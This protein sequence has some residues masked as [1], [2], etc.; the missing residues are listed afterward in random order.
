MLGGRLQK[1]RAVN[2]ATLD[3]YS[4]IRDF[5]RKQ[6]SVAPENLVLSSRR[7]A[8][9][10][11]LTKQLIPIQHRTFHPS[12]LRPFSTSQF[13]ENSPKKHEEPAPTPENS[14]KSES[15]D[16]PLS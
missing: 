5:F 9:P 15:S 12:I 11:K 13:P 4:I 6:H 10:T 3:R 16:N 8:K 14:N 2:A 1:T 7:L